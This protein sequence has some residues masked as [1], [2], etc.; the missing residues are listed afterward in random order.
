ML[1]GIDSGGKT[2]DGPSVSYEK[3]IE[4]ASVMRT[5]KVYG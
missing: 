1:L 4:T 3:S 5:K 2:D